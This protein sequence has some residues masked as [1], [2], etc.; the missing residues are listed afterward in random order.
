MK[1]FTI[2]VVGMGQRGLCLLERLSATLKDFPVNS[3]LSLHLVD[4]AVPGQGIHNWDQPDHLLINTIAGQV[5]VYAD[6]SVTGAGPIYKGPTYL[7]WARERGYRRLNGRFVISEAGEEI[8]ENAY[9][10]RSLLGEYLTW[11]YDELLK[12]LPAYV[13]VFNHRREA[14]EVVPREDRKIEVQLEGGFSIVADFVFLTTGHANCGPDELDLMYEGWVKKGR[15]RNSHLNYYRTPYPISSLNAI[16]PEAKVAICGTGLTAADAISALTVGVGGKF[17]TIS[18]DRYRYIPCGREPEIT[19]YSRQGLPAAGRAINQKGIYG[20]YK[21]KFFTLK[22]VDEQKRK[23]E[24]GKL[25]WRRD[26]LPMLK[27][28]MAYVYHCSVTGEWVDPL[29]YEPS[30]EDEA[31]IEDLLYPVKEQYFTDHKEYTKFIRKHLLEDIA[32]CFAGSVDSPRKAAADML[33]DIRDN[34]RYAVDY[35]GLTPESHRDFL[36]SWCSISNRIGSGPPKERNIEL[37]ALM[38]AGI[39]TMFGPRPTLSYNQETDQFSLASTNLLE[40]AVK[41]FDVLIRAKV[42]LFKPET[43]PSPL[44]ANMLKSGVAVPYY[45]GDFHPGGIDIDVNCNV[46]NW[47]GESLENLWALGYVVEG[48]HF[49]T[50]VLPRPYANSRSVQDAGKAILSM[51]QQISSRIGDPKL[52]SF[53]VA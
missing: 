16:G 38:D 32:D 36:S 12:S 48:P 35:S 43:S 14:V 24:S 6:E 47:A 40:P 3:S 1:R 37:L 44:I 20:Q 21:A 10:P 26:L 25:D 51:I 39:V 46:I 33:R 31:A 49:Y 4:P 11:A 53:E 52:S 41:N 50:Y 13:S 29:A 45:N 7:E 27:K 23:S 15:A 30:E 28:E 22:F 19:L 5:T 2:V 42:E 18:A 9:L 17:E 8:D 34:I